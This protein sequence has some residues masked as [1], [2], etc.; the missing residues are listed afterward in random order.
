MASGQDGNRTRIFRF[1]DD[2]PQLCVP[3]GQKGEL[4]GVLFYR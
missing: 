4:R 3:E 2:N 1:R